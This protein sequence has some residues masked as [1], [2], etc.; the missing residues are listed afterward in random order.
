[1][2]RALKNLIKLLNLA[3]KKEKKYL[4]RF[5]PYCYFH[6]LHLIVKNIFS[7]QTQNLA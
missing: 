2:G 6:R 7:N 5:S 3:I 1:M 4:E